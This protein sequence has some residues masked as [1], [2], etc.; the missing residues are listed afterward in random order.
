MTPTSVPS[1]RRPAGI[2][3]VAAI[4][5]NLPRLLAAAA[6]I[7]PLAASVR[8]DGPG[9]KDTTF[10]PVLPSATVYTALYQ[11]NPLDNFNVLFSAGDF[12]YL[13]A[14][15][16]SNGMFSDTSVAPVYGNS[17]TRLVFTAVEE[18]VPGPLNGLHRL[19]LGGLFGQSQI[20]LFFK[21]PAQNITRILANGT[22]DTTFNVGGGANNFVTS[23]LPLA[24]G[25][26]V[27][28]GLF[29]T[30]DLQPRLR[31]VRLLGNGSIDAS[32]NNSS[33]ID[34]DVEALAEGIK[35]NA[36]GTVDGTTLVAGTFNH[37]G[38]LPITKL[39]RL[40]A[41]G[42]VIPSFHPV[43]D[44]RVLAITVQSNGKIVIGGEFTNIN[45]VPVSGLA[46]LNYDG[47]L[48]TSF[49]GSVA[50]LPSGETA[51]VAVYVLKP[52]SNGQIYVGGNFTF[53]SGAVRRY[54]GL[55]DANGAVQSFDPGINIID[56]V[57][58]VFIQPNGR[59]LIGETLGPKVNTVYQPSLIR[60]IGATNTQ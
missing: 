32:F 43:I 12:G 33:A 16:P 4:A 47:S 54:L 23:I 28:G 35:E 45:G 21:I 37:V 22:Q 14:D 2:A 9:S 49:T 58:S 40:D 24:N 11:I 50:G 48:D 27:V 53:V 52:L 46:R 3:P 30:F 31:I 6:L 17:A 56:K 51:P 55:I 59:L 13:A 41:S 8:A 1:P 36:D 15:T 57:Q 42:N 7:L 44:T 26:M 20:Q 5:R 25:S 38:G 29:T 60:L 34:D 19:L 18:R 39:A 10:T